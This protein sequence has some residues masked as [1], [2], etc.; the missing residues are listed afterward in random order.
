M[1]SVF[2]MTK[3]IITLRKWSFIKT[4][5]VF[6]IRT[7]WEVFN[8][9]SQTSHQSEIFIICGVKC[10]NSI[11]TRPSSTYYANFIFCFMRLFCNDFTLRPI[12][13][14]LS[15][16]VGQYLLF[17]FYFTIFWQIRMIR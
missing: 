1:Q 3:S 10:P 4:V 2:S 6:L 14:N 5:E 15:L 12:T 11:T 17:V 9:Y 16:F 8:F 13:K 7:V